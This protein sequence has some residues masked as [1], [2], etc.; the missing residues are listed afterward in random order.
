MTKLE[1]EKNEEGMF[2]RWLKDTDSVLS[3]TSELSPTFFERNLHVW[4]QLWRVTEV[5]DIL[6]IL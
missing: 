5:S 6:C 4:R 2:Q 1:V 3:G